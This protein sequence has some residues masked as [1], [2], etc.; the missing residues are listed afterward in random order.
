MEQLELPLKFKANTYESYT[1]AQKKEH[2]YAN[3]CIQLHKIDAAVRMLQ[4][5]IEQID[6]NQ[7]TNKAVKTQARSVWAHSDAYVKGRIRKICND[8]KDKK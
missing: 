2:W 4:G 8:L 7:E 6:R 3:Y 1:D 5:L